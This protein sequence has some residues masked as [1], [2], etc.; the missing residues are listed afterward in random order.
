M[1]PTDQPAPS[2]MSVTTADSSRSAPASS[3][4]EAAASPV[5][6]GAEGSGAAVSED[7]GNATHTPGAEALQERPSSPPPEP[8][9]PVEIS[10]NSLHDMSLAEL[11]ALAASVNYKINAARTKHQLIYDVLS[12]M[13]DHRTRVLVEGVLEIGTE[14]FGLIRYPKY[15]FNALPE[16]VFIPLFLVRKFGLRPGNSIRG[17]A[18]APKDKDKYL[19]IDR[20]THV[21]GLEIDNYQSPTHFDK[22]TA[23]FPKQRIILETPKPCPVS[24]RIMDLMAPLG[25]GQRGLINASPRSGKTMILKDIAKCIVHNHKEITLI[26]LLLDERPEEVTDFE[27]SVS[28]CEIYSSTFDESPKRHCQLAELVRERA[29]RLVELGKDVVILLDSLTRLARGYNSM[30]GSGK[31][32]RTGSGGL[33]TKALVKPKKFFG[34]ARNVEEGGSLTI[35]ASALIETESKMD[36]VIFEEFKGTG[37][38]EATL[39]REIAERRIFPAIH[40]LKSGTRKDDLLYHP[41][42]FRRI[43]AIRRQLAQVPAT[44]ALELL[45]RNI[46]RTGN[47]AEILLTGLK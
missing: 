30:M 19:A 13:A 14:N 35:I 12:W 32:S 31:G 26:I 27:E 22:L 8:P 34:A 44:E 2:E 10:L 20:I 6:S 46:N 18:R 9:F 1:N 7:A 25:K 47:N 4:D 3:Q 45:I 23:T 28:G 41:D 38:M 39:D 5:T 36:E 40:L 33:D 37:N 24:A 17:I 43:M 42:E 16:D 15:S 21:D 11:Q 29:C